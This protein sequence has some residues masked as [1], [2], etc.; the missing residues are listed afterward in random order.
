MIVLLLGQQD[1]RKVVHFRAAQLFTISG[2][3]DGLLL[4]YCSVCAKLVSPHMILDL[5]QAPSV[6]LVLH[7]KL[8]TH[9]GHSHRLA[10][11]QTCILYSCAIR[12]E[13]MDSV[14]LLMLCA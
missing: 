14:Y 9:P 13:K 1:T 2:F 4:V 11:S 7:A 6:C 8:A 3:T 5:S 12:T 10:G